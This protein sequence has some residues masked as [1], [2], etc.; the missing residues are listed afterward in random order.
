MDCFVARA[1]RNDGIAIAD[2]AGRAKNHGARRRAVVTLLG[3]RRYDPDVLDGASLQRPAEMPFTGA[4]ALAAVFG[5]LP[6]IEIPGADEASV[7]IHLAG[8][9]GGGAVRAERIEKRRNHA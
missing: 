3:A 9:V 6:D 7:Q 2:D 5:E 4:A 1:P 8:A